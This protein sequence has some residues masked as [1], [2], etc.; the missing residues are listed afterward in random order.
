MNILKWLRYFSAYPQNDRLVRCFP[1]GQ[2]T[3]IDP[4]NSWMTV[5]SSL[6][7][8]F[9]FNPRV[10]SLAS[11]RGY[12][13]RP[14]GICLHLVTFSEKHKLDVDL[15]MVFKFGTVLFETGSSVN[16]KSIANKKHHVFNSAVKPIRNANSNSGLSSKNWG[17]S[18]Y[19]RVSYTVC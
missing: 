1:G 3:T 15:K 12:K 5:P 8:V 7:F 19:F 4:N 2:S 17:S 6:A 16:M 14:G 11:C 9:P 18:L 10:L 13:A